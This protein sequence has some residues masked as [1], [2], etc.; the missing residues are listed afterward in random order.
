MPINGKFTPYDLE[1]ANKALDYIRVHF[2]ETISAEGLALEVG[3]DIKLL[4]KIILALTEKTIHNFILDMRLQQAV[5]DLSN[6]RISISSIAKNLGFSDHGH[7][8]RVFKKAM[9]KTPTDYRYELMN[10]SNLI[11]KGEVNADEN[12]P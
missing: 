10:K 4:R 5:I 2:R 3:I 6:F 8:D 11:D 12:S 7:F 9:G 1:R